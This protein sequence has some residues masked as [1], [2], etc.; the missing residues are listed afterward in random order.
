MA[1]DDARRG[2]ARRAERVRT[3][4]AQ[5]RA[6]RDRVAVELEQWQALERSLSAQL[7][8]PVDAGDRGLVQQEVDRLQ[9]LVERAAER[10]D[11]IQR[12]LDRAAQGRLAVCDRCDG[13]IPLERLLALP[14]SALCTECTEDAEREDRRQ[15]A[16]EE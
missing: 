9:P 5:L 14:G 4:A 12:L 11:E 15:K 8:E 7:S 1:A 16:A 13:Q 2:D 3:F 6:E 10:I